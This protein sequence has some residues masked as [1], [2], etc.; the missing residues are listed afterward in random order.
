MRKLGRDTFNERLKQTM[1]NSEKSKS[2]AQPKNFPIR[3][4]LKSTEL[5]TIEISNN[6]QRWLRPRRMRSREKFALASL[7]AYAIYLMQVAQHF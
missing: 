5:I 2:K 7:F 4:M 1:F 6:I 3:S